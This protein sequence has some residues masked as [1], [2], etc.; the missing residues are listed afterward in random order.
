MFLNL[1]WKL[2]NNRINFCEDS[3]PITYVWN[4]FFDKASSREGASARVV[5]VSHTQETIYLSYKL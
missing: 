5:F 1:P 2:E 4:M 3:P